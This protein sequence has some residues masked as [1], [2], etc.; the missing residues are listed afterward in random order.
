MRSFLTR[1]IPRK[2]DNDSLCRVIKE[3]WVSPKEL[4]VKA[5][6]IINK[7]AKSSDKLESVQEV[8]EEEAKLSPESSV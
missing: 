4:R 5:E 8:I 1:L 3:I 2:M 6:V 7:K